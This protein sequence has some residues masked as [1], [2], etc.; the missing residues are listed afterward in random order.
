MY[1]QV[2]P[3]YSGSPSKQTAAPLKILGQQLVITERQIS[4]QQRQNF[5]TGVGRLD[6]QCLFQSLGGFLHR[7]W[8]QWAE[9][10]AEWGRCPLRLLLT[11]FYS[12]RSAFSLP[13][14]PSLTDASISQIPC[15]LCSRR[16]SDF[17][18]CAVYVPSATGPEELCR[19]CGGIWSGRWDL[20]PLRGLLQHPEAPVSQAWRG[21]LCGNQ[22]GEGKGEETWM[23][24]AV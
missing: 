12:V 15:G 8:T 6:R 24:P 20:P 7:L 17:L 14:P 16:P 21:G 23:L 3:S 19:V 10:L 4:V 5:L 22:R 1:F 18:L 13:K 9:R 11:S 2:P